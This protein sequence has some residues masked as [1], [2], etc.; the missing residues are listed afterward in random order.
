MKA[1]YYFIF[2]LILVLSV[3]L[4]SA[5][6]AGIFG[7]SVFKDLILPFLII[8]VIIFAILQKTQ[9][10]GEEKKQIDALVSLVIALLLI[11]MPNAREFIVNSLTWFVVGVIV[12]FIF[13]ILYGFVAGDKWAEQSWVKI[14]FGILAGFFVIGLVIY[15][16]GLWD[17][18]K[19]WF[20]GTGGGEVLT[21][22][23]L[24]AIIAG[25]MAI[26]LT[27]GKK[28]NE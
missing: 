4:T 28:N 20:S 17:I 1:I 22:I 12:I 24:I 15:V 3:S 13:L 8:F 23:F 19:G 18:V 2:A 26:A 25:A 10:L 9:I 14:V 11:G 6:D 5:Q 21:N 7:S 16:G 27:S